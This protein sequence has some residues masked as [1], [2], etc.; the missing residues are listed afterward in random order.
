M[1]LVLQRLV[2]MNCDCSITLPNNVSASSVAIKN[3][4]NRVKLTV[5]KNISKSIEIEGVFTG[6]L[7]SGYR[8]EEF[9]ISPSSLEISGPSSLL[10][11]IETAKITLNESNLTETYS[12]MLP[13]EFFDS[14]ED[15][16]MSPDLQCT[17]TEVYA[18]Y[19]IAFWKEVALKVLF[20][21]GG[22]ADKDDVTYTVE[23]EKVQISGASSVVAG[24]SEVVLGRIDLSQVGNTGRYHFSV[25]LP[26]GV[27]C[28]SGETEAVVTVSV[29]GLS[30]KTLEVKQVELVNLPEGYEAELTSGSVRVT[31][32]GTQKA[33]E[34]ITAEQIKAIADLSELTAAGKYKVKVQLQLASTEEAGVLNEGKTVSVELREL[35]E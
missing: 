2:S 13:V 23:P 33:V 27:K 8:A 1:P 4:D 11:R 31:V 6:S 24:L 12:G 19:P 10:D 18:V 29:N 22:G 30:T 25:Q 5:E 21:P 32:R 17:V 34:A 15:K 35:G 26:N 16:V 7:A 9:I 3:R 28:E 20:V 14:N